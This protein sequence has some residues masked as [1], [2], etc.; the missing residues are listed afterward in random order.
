[1]SHSKPAVPT[2]ASR[3]YSKLPRYL[4]RRGQLF[5]FKRK[6]P[7]DLRHVFGDGREQHWKALGTTLLEKA[8]VL[9]AVEVSEFDFE[10]A[11]HRRLNAAN[12]AG[13]RVKSDG[14]ASGDSNDMAANVQMPGAEMHQCLEMLHTLQE[15]LMGISAARTGSPQATGHH[16]PNGRPVEV[17]GTM[18]PVQPIPRAPKL[19]KAMEALTERGPRK[20]TLTY[21]LEDWKRKQT[22]HRTINAVQA[23]VHEFRDVHGSLAVDAI[24]RRHARDYR[25]RLVEQGLSKGTIENRIG[26]LSTLV[27]HGMLEIVE[28]LPKNPFERIQITGGSGKRLKK[29]RRAYE[30]SEL[31]ALYS[32]KMY[33]GE[34]KPKGQVVEAA[35]WLPILGP[36]L[37][38][39]IEELCQLRTP[40][41][42]RI[43]GEW[44]VRICDLGE[45][46]K[47]KN[48]GSFRRVPLHELVIKTGFLVHVAEMAKAGHDRVFPSLSNVNANGNYSN[49]AGKW[50][51]RYLSSIGLAD[52]RLDYHS[53]RYLF[54]QQNSFCDIADEAR[55][56]LTGHWVGKSDGGRTY[57]KGENGQYSFPTLVNAIKK[58][59]YDDLRI[60]HLF[61]DEPF[62]G[63]EDALIR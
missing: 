43:N 25:D 16:E 35:Y 59:K 37:G 57:L 32:S 24:T 30:I 38:A 13:V 2:T 40:D 53:F 51:G 3:P 50:Y 14:A 1:M 18:R 21:L 27:R 56:A 49:A 12:Q 11:K 41:I 58:L 6:I 62:A 28:D 39:R 52:H 7:A 61:V 31:N 23:A 48:S 19:T 63:V 5:Y 45:A 47:I 54:R 33:C 55:D 29:D 17:D 9:L 15:R 8:R 26:F 46:Q 22:R 60:D 20:P 42:Q 34:Y 10:V 36:F 44:C 4:H